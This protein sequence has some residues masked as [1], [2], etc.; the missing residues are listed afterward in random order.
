MT[1]PRNA[2]RWTK[3]QWGGHDRWACTLC[4]FDTLDYG[5][6]V[7][8]ARSQHPRAWDGGQEEAPDPLANV[9]FGSPKALAEARRLELVREDFQGRTPSGRTGFTVAD[10]QRAAS[11]SQ[12]E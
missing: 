8:H 7:Q 3:S 9:V 5:A 10:V 11:T 1:A 4:R 6:M 2:P 12:E